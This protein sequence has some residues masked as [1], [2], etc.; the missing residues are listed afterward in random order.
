MLEQKGE[1]VVDRLGFDQMVVIED[2]KDPVGEG[3]Y[4]VDQRGIDRIE[5]LSRNHDLSGLPMISSD[6]LTDNLD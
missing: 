2:E 5:R 3:G 1:A 6:L 4:L